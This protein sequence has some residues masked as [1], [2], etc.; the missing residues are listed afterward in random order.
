MEDFCNAYLRQ[1]RLSALNFFP[2]L[3]RIL[4]VFYKGGS[5]SFKCWS[6]TFTEEKSGTKFGRLRTKTLC[7]WLLLLKKKCN[8]LPLKSRTL[9]SVH[10]K[11]EVRA[12]CKIFLGSRCIR[13]IRSIHSKKFGQRKSLKF[14]IFV[15]LI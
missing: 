2:T 3:F 1:I 8:G 13:F 6:F 4:I 14:E 12:C 10:L 5:I 9:L 7:F 15:L 11:E